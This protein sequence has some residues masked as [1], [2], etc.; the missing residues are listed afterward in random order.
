M[1]R[2]STPQ[3]GILMN[4]PETMQQD[5]H[6]IVS[7]LAHVCWQPMFEEK[8]GGQLVLAGCETCA[9]CGGLE[10]HKGHESHC[11]LV[12]LG[13]R[14]DVPVQDAPSPQRLVVVT[15]ITPPNPPPPRF[16]WMEAPADFFAD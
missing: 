11:P 15:R 4:D 6:A 5:L 9:L 13:A 2:V 1:H 12:A 3:K 16:A 10:Q 8:A 7:L 14:Y